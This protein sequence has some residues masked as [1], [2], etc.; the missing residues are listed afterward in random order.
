M[1]CSLFLVLV[2]FAAGFWVTSSLFKLC[3]LKYAYNELQ[4]IKAPMAI[5][6]FLLNVIELT[7]LSLLICIKRKRAT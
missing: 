3:W 2:R 4:Q 7:L 1:K 5:S 6:G